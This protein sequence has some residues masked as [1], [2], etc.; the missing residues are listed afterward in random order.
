[1][2]DCGLS[3]VL[4]NTNWTRVNDKFHPEIKNKCIEDKQSNLSNKTKYDDKIVAFTNT[5]AFVQKY[6]T[7]QSPYKGLFLYHSVGSGKT[8]TAIATATNS[9]NKEGYT[10]IWVTR[11]TLKE[12]IWKNMFV[13][14][15]NII[16]RDKLKSGEI[17]DI[18]DTHIKR[19]ELYSKKLIKII[20]SFPVF[21]LKK[22]RKYNQLELELKFY[23][24]DKII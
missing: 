19:L 24:N 10:I 16:I 17:K 8:C 2:V 3:N 23:A 5:Q 7:P 13:K 22:K 4:I 9:F 18:P 15:C 14:I 1:M 20:K 11:Y 21:K 6:L 12:D